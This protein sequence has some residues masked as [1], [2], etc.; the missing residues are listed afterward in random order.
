MILFAVYE[1]L[2][3]F[4][5]YMV[6]NFSAVFKYWRSGT[7]FYVMPKFLACVASQWVWK[8]NFNFGYYVPYFYFGRFWGVEI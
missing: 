3:L 1:L 5:V 8:I 7:V 6:A 4:I 2:G